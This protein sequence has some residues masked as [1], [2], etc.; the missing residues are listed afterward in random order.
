MVQALEC[1]NILGVD[2]SKLKR[3]A[4]GLF[5]KSYWFT[6]GWT[7]SDFLRHNI[8]GLTDTHH[9]LGNLMTFRTLSDAL[10]DIPLS[11]GGYIS[12]ILGSALC[13]SAAF[14]CGAERERKSQPSQPRTRAGDPGGDP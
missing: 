9:L 3:D 4:L 6:R 13:G 10:I 12:L 5:K 7:P 11:A 1:L 8:N 14:L 2:Q